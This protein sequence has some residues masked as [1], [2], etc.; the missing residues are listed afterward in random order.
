MIELPLQ[1]DPDAPLKVL[2]LGAHSDDIEIG[3]GGTILRLTTLYPKASFHWIVFSAESDERNGEA[4][5]GAGRF[6]AGA[7]RKDVVVKR[8][9]ES[10]FP[11]AGEEIK[12]YFEAL[13][14]AVVP[15]LVFTHFRFDLHQDHKVISDLTWNTFRGS[16]ILEYEIPKWDGDLGAPNCFVRLTEEILERK[17]G[18]ICETFASQRAKAWF[19][20]D[21][22]RALARLRGIEANAQYAEAFYARKFV[23]A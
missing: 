10:F 16:L 14:S 8:F 7:G 1:R 13:K 23:V 22:F 20:A 21:T 19:T 3:C 11:H 5:V 17:I 6:L 18:A 15:D 12:E 4:L 9:R 2:C